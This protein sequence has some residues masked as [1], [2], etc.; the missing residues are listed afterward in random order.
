MSL[1]TKKTISLIITV[2]LTIQTT[3]FAQT[4]IIDLE[5]AEN[6]TLIHAK[7]DPVDYDGKQAVKVTTLPNNSQNGLVIIQD[8]NFENG[9]IELDLAGKPVEN[10][11]AYAKGFIGIAFRAD[12][13]NPQNHE[14]FYLRPVNA[15]AED[16]TFRN[17]SVQYS[18]HP[19][20]SWNVL[21]QQF[22]GKY[23]TYAKMEPGKWF[24]IKIVVE[25]KKASFYVHDME[26][27]C[28]VVDDLL[29]G[30]R[31]GGVALWTELTTEAYFSNLK[32]TH[33]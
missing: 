8:L 15:I 23:E 3:I 32:I 18:S 20:N 25:D 17:R 14:C 29:H 27:P 31:S 9:I 6:L 5:K 13:N 7:V 33:N 2:L 4:N 1:P 19:D 30:L 24:H 26:T 12:K 10:A 21:R 28:L 11:P 16:E 22:P